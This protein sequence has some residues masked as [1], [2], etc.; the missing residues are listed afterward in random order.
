[1]K[2]TIYF[3]WVSLVALYGMEVSWDYLMTLCLTNTY[4]TMGEYVIHR[5]GFHDIIRSPGMTR[6]HYKHHLSPN[7]PERLFIPIRVT[8]IND[9]IFAAAVY[10]V[11]A[12]ASLWK[13]LSSAHVSYLLFEWAHYAIH[14]VNMRR[15]IPRRLLE[16]HESHH[17]DAD[18][19]FAFTTPYW[20]I[21]GGTM[22]RPMP[23]EEYP[24]SW[25]PLSLIS[26]LSIHELEVLTN[27]I[28][29][30]P[31]VEAWKRGWWNTAF[32]YAGTGLV[33]GVYHSAVNEG[34]KTQEAWRRI[35][36]LWATTYL[37]TSVVIWWFYVCIAW[38]P[39]VWESVVWCVASLIVF[40]FDHQTNKHGYWHLLWH[41]LT[42]V[43]VGWMVSGVANT[44]AH[45]S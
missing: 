39:L 42:G 5:W 25:L 32:I 41:L 17:R 37:V 18:Y 21:M 30:W 11:G 4:Y 38:H 40:W 43:G 26:F 31:A 45:E 1:M 7:D 44:R 12:G 20:D 15:W 27:V 13:W 23:I 19:H 36:H 34:G 6:A 8:L 29:L 35:D 10:G 24:L 9:T 16:F 22:K 2:W 33:S 14:T 3:T 28:Y